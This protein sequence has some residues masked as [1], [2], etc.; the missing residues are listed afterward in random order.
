MVISRRRAAETELIGNLLVAHKSL[1]VS[2]KSERE[3]K[4][5]RRTTSYILKLLKKTD[6]EVIQIV[7]EGDSERSGNPP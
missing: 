3:A 4:A 2:C 6:D 1:A 5:L 7:S